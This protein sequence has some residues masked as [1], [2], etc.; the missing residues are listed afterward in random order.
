MVFEICQENLSWSEVC[1]C[2]LLP[3]P[4]NLRAILSYGCLWLR[5]ASMPTANSEDLTAELI[6]LI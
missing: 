4:K 5:H 2:R 6:I 3:E 1:V